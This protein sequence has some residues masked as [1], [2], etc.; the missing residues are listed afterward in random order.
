[1]QALIID[2]S[3]V[4]RA[5]IAEVLTG[6]G[7]AVRQADDGAVALRRLEQEARVD[8]V[9]V[10]QNLPGLSGLQVVAALRDRPES[11]DVKVLMVSAEGHGSFL[12][13][14]LAAGVDEYLFKPF[15][16]DALAGKIELLR[17][18]EPLEADA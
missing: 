14:A 5:L 10:D 7:F 17:L 16:C 9:V 3:A 15:T 13:Q 18:R 8:L 11:R 2:D 4:M 12:Q 6:L 1:M